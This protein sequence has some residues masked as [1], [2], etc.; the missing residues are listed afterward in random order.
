MNAPGLVAIKPR[1]SSSAEVVDEG[2][3]GELENREK[4]SD[5]KCASSGKNTKNVCRRFGDHEVDH[6]V[7]HRYDT[8][9]KKKRRRFIAHLQ[10]DG[11]QEEGKREVDPLGSIVPGG[12][13]M[14]KNSSSSPVRSS[15]VYGMTRA[16]RWSPGGDGSTF[17]TP[18]S[19]TSHRNK[20]TRNESPTG[21]TGRTRS[22]DGDDHHKEAP[23]GEVLDAPGVLR[24]KIAEIGVFHG[25]TSLHQIKHCAPLLGEEDHVEGSVGEIT[26]SATTNDP[27]SKDEDAKGR[28]D[29]DEY[30]DLSTTTGAETKPQIVLEYHLID[31][32]RDRE[33]EFESMKAFLENENPE[34]LQDLLQEQGVGR[35]N[36][37]TGEIY[38]SWEEK[39]VE[40][41]LARSEA[42]N[43]NNSY[44]RGRKTRKT[45]ENDRRPS[46]GDS[47]T[48]IGGPDEMGEKLD[49]FT[50]PEEHQ[51][52]AQ[53]VE[54]AQDDLDDT[55]VAYE[56]AGNE[57]KMI[58]KPLSI[59]TSGDWKT[60]NPRMPKTFENEN[61][62]KWKNVERNKK[63]TGKLVLKKL[64]NELLL[65]PNVDELVLVDDYFPGADQGDAIQHEANR[66]D[67]HQVMNGGPGRT[68]NLANPNSARGSTR[69]NTSSSG[70]T[71]PQR[72]AKK[73]S[74]STTM[75]S[76]LT[77]KG[78]EADFDADLRVKVFLHRT[79]SLVASEQFFSGKVVGREGPRDHDLF[80]LVFIDG[81]HTLPGIISDLEQ[82]A[83]KVRPETGV[84]AG[85]DFAASRFPAIPVA[86][87]Y[88]VVPP[89]ARR[90]WS[91]EDG[92]HR[93]DLQQEAA[94]S[95]AS[96]LVGTATIPFGQE[97]EQEKRRSEPAGGSTS[98][99]KIDSLFEIDE[100]VTSII[101]D[102]RLTDLHARVGY[103]F[104]PEIHLDT[105]YVWWV[106]RK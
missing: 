41:F 21:S 11:E 40:A 94:A 39:L 74:L 19:T 4:T 24:I 65:E 62:F 47:T 6:H 75:S 46:D 84:L 12:I 88:F 71:A 43:R 31:P 67:E 91:V 8:Y 26:P 44:K 87:S 3:V 106:K 92:T 10:S 99:A 9:G 45:G 27:A 102:P 38:P 60:N 28:Y 1:R 85:H 42:G 59:E 93:R 35:E 49:S 22:T 15:S 53:Q 54:D 14:K 2:Q 105:D 37:F 78:K 52:S 79:S 55:R 61:V 23:E 18:S 77:L 58:T 17:S 90:G 13:K 86:L 81:D 64:I 89:S 80:D 30:D 101:P 98:A 103:L 32:W 51:P 66:A 73:V 48:E 70:G 57:R 82:Y 34:Y 63:I 7:D 56:V 16:R 100:E 36:M 68:D 97:K 95:S 69:M 96:V 29:E 33:L 83:S 72:R 76:N 5:Q 20:Q 25:E 50:V 104:E